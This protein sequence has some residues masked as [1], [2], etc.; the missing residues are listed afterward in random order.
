ML[1]GVTYA[2][3]DLVFLQEAPKGL[4][5]IVFLLLIACD[6][7]HHERARLLALGKIQIGDAAAG[8]LADAPIA[9][10][11]RAAE[12]LRLRAHP[13]AVRQS[14]RA[15]GLFFCGGAERTHQ[16][17]VIDLALRQHRL[18]AQRAAPA[19]ALAALASSRNT[20]TGANPGRAGDIAQPVKPAAVRAAARDQHGIEALREKL[21]RQHTLRPRDCGR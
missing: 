18:C 4:V 12:A 7:E 10:H 19:R 6:F 9:A 13:A 17:F 20:M 21:R 11:E 2:A 5:E 1:G 15:I 16:F 14:A 3:H 8:E